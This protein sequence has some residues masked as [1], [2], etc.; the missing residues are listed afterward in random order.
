MFH[1]ETFVKYII[2]E[3][4][5]KWICSNPDLF[6]SCISESSHRLDPFNASSSGM[7]QLLAPHIFLTMAPLSLNAR[8]F[9]ISEPVLSQ[10]VAEVI[11]MV[12]VVS[13]LCCC[14]LLLSLPVLIY[15]IV[16]RFGPINMTW[17]GSL[18]GRVF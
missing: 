12:Q 14:S 15:K 2:K 11:K 4:I 18:V 7:Q 3:D 9:L 13:D 10:F 1:S 17:A 6:R 16:L 5:N 8:N